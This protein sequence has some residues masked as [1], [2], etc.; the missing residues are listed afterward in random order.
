VRRQAF[1]ALAARTR[2]TLLAVY[3]PDRLPPPSAEQLAAEKAAAYAGFRQAYAELKAGWGGY[4]R[5]DAWV[6]SANNA[7]FGALAAYDEW[8]GAF[9]ALFH[10]GSDNWPAFYT[11]TRQ[12]AALPRE[13]R[14]ARLQQ[15]KA[16]EHQA[17]RPAPSPGPGGR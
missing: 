11:A 10:A 2:Q 9:E 17:F 1:R 12:L 15:L 4:D 16:G 14:T 13:A 8:V 3:A 5:Y 7:A 6:A